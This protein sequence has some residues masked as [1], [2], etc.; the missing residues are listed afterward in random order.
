MK[1]KNPTNFTELVNVNAQHRSPPALFQTRGITEI[2]NEHHEVAVQVAKQYAGV[3]FFD[4]FP[5]GNRLPF[6]FYR[7]FKKIKNKF[8]CFLTKYYSKTSSLGYIVI[9]IIKYNDY[10]I[11]FC[12]EV[13]KY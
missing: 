12:Y 10:I 1:N 6:S 4:R 3:V 11:C 7:L 8:K 5:A 2:E 9:T 13:N